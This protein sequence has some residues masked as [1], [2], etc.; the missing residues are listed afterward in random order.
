MRRIAAAAMLAL[1]LP[2]LAQ[3]TCPPRGAMGSLDPEQRLMMMAD[4][5][6]ATADGSLSMQDYRAMQR[7]KLKTMTPD[8]R[9]AWAAGLTKEW[10]ALTPAEQAKL[11]A[12]SEAFRKEHQGSWRG[13]GNCPPPP[14]G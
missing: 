4:A 9:Q 3:Q 5:R 1:S 10:N 8:Q 12:D 6:K 2:A 7:G 11:K 13:D 14:N